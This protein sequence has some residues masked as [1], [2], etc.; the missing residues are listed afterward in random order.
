MIS[1]FAMNFIDR[2]LCPI[3]RRPAGWPRSHRNHL[4]ESS[5]DEIVET[6]EEFMDRLDQLLLALH[7]R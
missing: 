2:A 7:R 5:V 6:T 3:A 1:I 4:S